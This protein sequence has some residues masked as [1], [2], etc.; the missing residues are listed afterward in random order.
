MKFVVLLYYAVVPEGSLGVL[1][2]MD[3]YGLAVRWLCVLFEDYFL[4]HGPGLDDF[5]VVCLRTIFCTKVVVDWMI[6][7]RLFEDYGLDL[8]VLYFALF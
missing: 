5:S 1:E 2:A 4:Y 7:S 6:F 8:V 3:A